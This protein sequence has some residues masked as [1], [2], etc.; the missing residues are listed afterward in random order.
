MA[1]ISL[2]DVGPDGALAFL[3]Q[4]EVPWPCGYGAPIESLARFGAYSTE[5][6]SGSYNP[7]YEVNPT[8]YLLRPDGRVMWHDEQSRPRHRGTTEEIV[9]RAEAAIEAALTSGVPAGGEV[10]N[11]GGHGQ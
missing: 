3:M 2:T 7:G 6:M 8:L 4:F 10:P 11:G 5:R 1:F 9:A